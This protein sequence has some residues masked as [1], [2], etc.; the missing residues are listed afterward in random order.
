[1]SDRWISFLTDNGAR[2]VDGRIADFG[3]PA[4]EI[5][6][7]REETIICDL[8]HEGVIQVAG[9][10]APTFLHAQL[11]N[12]VLALPDDGA[13]WNGWCSPKGRLLATF[14]LWRD[15]AAISLMLPRSIQATIQK[16]LQMFV[17]RAKVRLSDESA[18]VVQIGIAGENAQAALEKIFGAAPTGVMSACKVD[19]GRIMR[20]SEKRFVFV[21]DT[22]RAL[23]VW[24]SLALV[25]RQ[26]GAPVWDRFGIDDGILTVLP[27]TQDQFVPQMANFELAGG[28]SF[29]KGCYPGQEIVAR[30][31]YRGIL[32]RR[33]VKVR[34]TSNAMPVPG[35]TVFAAEFGDQPA[36]MFASVAPSPA[37]GFV[38]LVVAQL[39]AIKANS[40]RMESLN[41][42]PLTIEKLPY[43]IPEIA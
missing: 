11:T 33:M 34:G 31:Q 27:A 7:S 3:D 4:A 16:R 6:A 40:L 2:F 21:G 19:G 28:V 39:E 30:T 43:D 42:S 25:G 10:D 24:T 13:Q 32:K 18:N 23:A 35:Q 17:L 36:G 5:A 38:A 8:S 20:L 41:G 14:L 29:K 12:D 15:D 1:M 26:V 9:E 22:E 37:G